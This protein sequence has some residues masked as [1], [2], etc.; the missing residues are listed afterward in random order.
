MGLY[1]EF[2]Q[3]PY[4]DDFDEQKNFHRIL[5]K[6]GV[7]V[8]ARELTQLQTILQNQVERFG[9][10]IL[11]EGTIVQGCNFSEI[12]N[13]AYIKILDLNTNGQPVVLSNYD[14]YTIQGANTGVKGVIQTYSTG[15][16]SQDPDLNTLYFKYTTSGSSNAEIKVFNNTENLYILD[17]SNNL[18][19]TVTAA[20]SILATP[21]DAVGKSY[22]VKVGDGIIYQKGFFTRV[23]EQL[24]VVSKYSNTPNNVVVGF[25]TEESIVD[26]NADTSLLDNANG[27]NNYNAPGADRLKLTPVLTVK[28]TDEAKVDSTFFAIQEYMYGRV[29]RRNNDTQYSTIMNTI[30]KRTKE[31]SGNY[32]VSNFIISTSNSSNTSAVSLDINKGVA[33]VEGKRVELL[34][35]YSIDLPKAN[36]TMIEESQNISTNYGNYVLVKEYMGHFDINLGANVA[37]YDTTQTNGTD[38]SIPSAAN[39]SSI[40]TAK[41]MSI[42]H[43]SG[44][45]GNANAVYKVYLSD[46]RMNS[47]KNWSSV[48]SLVYSANVGTADLV[49]TTIYEQGFK[50]RIYPIGREA[51]A[52][53]PAANTDAYYT[54]RSVNNSI[55]IP[56]NGFVSFTLPSGEWPY[57]V[58]ALNSDQKKDLILVAGAT[59]SPYTKNKAID[60]SSATVT[61]TNTT[62]ITISVTAPSG[63]MSDNTLYYNAKKDTITAPSAKTLNSV[64]VKIACNTAGTSGPYTLG[65][66]DAYTIEGIWVG[67]TVIGYQDSANT[68]ADKTSYFILNNGQK[69]DYYGLATVSK[70]SGITLSANS[71]L[72]VKLKVFT[73][74]SNTGFFTVNSYP[75]DDANTANTAA[76]QTYTIPKYTGEDGTL[77]N[78]RD[79][80]DFRPYA[81]NTAVYATDASLAT[82]NPASTVSFNT[83]NELYIAAPNK[84]LV[85][86]YNYYLGRKDLVMINEYGDFVLKTG[87]PAENPLPPSDPS[88]G[89]VL[90]DIN[91]PPYPTLPTSVANSSKVP[92]YGVSVTT[93]NNR[94]YTMKDVGDIEQRVKNL[95]YYSSLNLLEVETKDL[96]ISDTNG[97]NRF[98]NGILVDNFNDLLGAEIQDPEWQAG[99]DNQTKEL[100]PL[101]REYPLRVKVDGTVT[102]TNIDNKTSIDNI[103]LNRNADFKLIEQPYATTYRRLAADVWSFN[104]RAI[105]Y[106]QYDGGRDTTITPEPSKGENIY[107]Y[108]T[109]GIAYKDGGKVGE[110][111]TTLDNSFMRPQNIRI[112]VS[113]LRPNTRHYFAFDG[114]KVTGYVAPGQYASSGNSSPSNIYAKD[115]GGTAVYSDSAGKLLAV[116]NMPGNKFHVGE[117]KLEI[118]DVDDFTTIDSYISY[119]SAYYSSYNFYYTTKSTSTTS[120]STSSSSLV[121]T[122]VG[123]FVAFEPIAQTF[124]IRADAGKDSVVVLS[125]VDLYFKSKPA[126]ST[127]HG[128]TVEI[129]ETENG[130]PSAN[131]RVENASIYLKN[132]SV[133]TSGAGASKT[134]VRFTDPVVLK[135]NHEYSIVIIPDQNDP[136]F[137][138]FTSR[139]GQTDLLNTTLQVTQDTFDGL[140][141][142]SSNGR[143][144]T[145]YQDENLKFTLY[146]GQYD[147]SGI[148][149]FTN[150]DHEFFTITPV[151]GTF[152]GG[153]DVIKINANLVPTIATNK[154]NN[155]I[156]TSSDLTSAFAAG[157]YLGYWAN[158]TVVDLLKV[159][160]ANST[161]IVCDWKPLFSNNAAKVFKSIGGSISYKNNTD[162]IIHLVGSV[163]KSGSAQTYFSVGNTIRGLSSQASATIASV[164]NLKMS[165]IHASVVQSNY[166]YTDTKYNVTIAVNANGVNQYNTASPLLVNADTAFNKTPVVI[167]SKSNE[168]VN[169]VTQS[170]RI[171]ANLDNTMTSAP[172]DSTPIINYGATSLNVFEYLVSNNST[173]ETLAVGGEALTRYISKVATLAEN[174]DAEDLS[175][176]VTGYRPSNT[177]IEVYVRFKNK[178]DPRPFSDIEWTKLSLKDSSNLISSSANLFDYKEF[179]YYVPTVNG[180]GSLTNAGGAALDISND[181]ILT[182][183]DPDGAVYTG[184]KYF[185]VKIVLLADNY[186]KVPKVKNFRAIALT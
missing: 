147:K 68:A 21:A 162:N 154:S 73:S 44:T 94:R 139:L 46:V 52:S 138:I 84:E 43:E 137:Q 40:G 150:D 9:N 79:C 31:E 6:P 30:E 50:R 12:T 159:V 11:K 62:N 57:S 127:G 41:V 15:L 4:Y 7:A 164:D 133:I 2:N 92:E 153:E 29:V 146:I 119:A 113:G 155:I 67:N 174:L 126:S 132:E 76:I 97:N 124:K 123:L 142:T 35:K 156:T 177:N 95:E 3:A 37:L 115:P 55:T 105:I 101:F 19:D 120:Q 103:T 114:V 18:I 143:A 170:F 173:N 32:T 13:L 23:D 116:F 77:Y 122:A 178:N 111:G 165:A 160:S 59:A 49:S 86:D 161:A 80:V 176:Y 89:M 181:N 25:Q 184:Y 85:S 107:T 91:V 104:G 125:K 87:A 151:S 171:T 163:A 186:S 72:L 51:I 118:A 8:Q 180:S 166:T 17:S 70:K 53:L 102:S 136:E 75:I 56:A 10:N 26:S 69:D 168:I 74:A 148:A 152:T 145:P 108:S 82:V 88:I 175:L 182:Y 48:K 149:Y 28:T 144:W 128:I 22:G 183:K 110:L 141:F 172:Y 81:V 61:V 20:G 60:L 42:I 54:F 90:A 83:S 121:S 185:A 64:Y 78:L 100:I 1:T 134:E 5:F 47:T 109:S 58:G 99:Y 169:S 45:I 66:P 140:L 36:T 38:G 157:D 16:E 117:R 34:N 129:R 131:K 93:R 179:E 158:N 14:G 96:I 167:M 98:K 33:Y 24:T 130:Y 112:Q 135:T 27:F 65:F 39:G 63:T 71:N 106:P